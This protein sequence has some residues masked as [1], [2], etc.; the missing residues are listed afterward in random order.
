V[1]HRP[2]YA[3]LQIGTLAGEQPLMQPPTPGAVSGV[4]YAE[5]SWLARGF[6]SPYYKDSHHRFHKAMRVFIDEVV[7]PDAVRC[8]ENGKR[9]SQEVVDKLWCVPPA[10]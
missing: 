6:K 3:R 9:I 10:V 2:Q 1:L 4:P 8:E 7:L 5:T